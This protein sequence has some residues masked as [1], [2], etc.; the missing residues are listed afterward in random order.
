MLVKRRRHSPRSWAVRCSCRNHL[1]PLL[2][3]D[4][5]SGFTETQSV[6]VL[7][8]LFSHIPHSSCVQSDLITLIPFLASI[9]L[10]FKIIFV[11]LCVCLATVRTHSMQ[12]TTT[13]CSISGTGLSTIWPLKR[14]NYTSASIP[15]FA[16]LR[17]GKCGRKPAL[18]KRWQRTMFVATESEQ[19]V[20]RQS[21][22]VND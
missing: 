7:Q 22:P 16:C 19:V 15:S 1:N 4:L 3:P 13:T 21:I 11:T 8:L 5:H 14:E 6:H 9:F 2:S 12:W 20:S 10:I 18:R 17:S